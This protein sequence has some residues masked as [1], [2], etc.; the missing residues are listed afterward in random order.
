V[1]E[2]ERE[3]ERVCAC[4]CAHPSHRNK[5][6]MARQVFSREMILMN[7]NYI[8]H[9]V[10]Y[11]KHSRESFHFTRVE[12]PLYFFPHISFL[13]FQPIVGSKERLL[14]L[15]RTSKWD[16]W[17]SARW[18]E[19]QHRCPPRVIVDDEMAPGVRVYA[20]ASEKRERERERESE[21]SR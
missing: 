11:T 14:S 21:Q 6:E 10:L 3:R 1:R 16:G 9:M 17:L 15:G 19:R 4:V 20:F 12:S 18:R 7:K 2:R 13:G 8:S 5:L